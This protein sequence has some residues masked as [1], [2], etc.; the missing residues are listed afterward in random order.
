MAGFKEAPPW[1]SALEGAGF[2]VRSRDGVPPPKA[3]VPLLLPSALG[4]WAA[5]AVASGAG[6]PARRWRSWLR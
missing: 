3:G 1:E 5:A 6:R 2:A 4:L